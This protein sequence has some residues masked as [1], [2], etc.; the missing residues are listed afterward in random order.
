MSEKIRIIIADDSAIIRGILEKVF[1]ADGN[2]EIVDLVSNGRKAVD[3]A[4]EKE[5]DLVIS[6]IDMPEL[7]GVEA[8][9]LI[10]GQL[11]IPVAIFSENEARR[12]DASRAGALLFEKKPA[13]SSLK[14]ETLKPFA[15]H[16]R[17]SFMTVKGH[18][19]QPHK[20]DP[21]FNTFKIVVL[22]ASTG[23]PSAV[24][25]VL[26][27]LGK[28]PLPILYAQHIDVGADGKMAEWFNE[29]CPEINFQL[30][31]DGQEALP[32]NVYMAP[33][34]KHLVIDYI[35][36]MGNAV[37]KLSDDPPERFLRPAVNK[38]FRS[39]ASHYKNA[40][41]AVLMTGMGQ[42]GAEGCKAVIENSGH[43]IVEDK[44]TCTV[45]GM[46]AAAIKLGAANEIIPR[47]KI[48]ARLLEL[49]K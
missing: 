16:V 31:K 6:D 47:D 43:T 17:K 40:C 36:P 7:D 24:Q 18:K 19:P 9:K 27:G 21:T 1:K 34:E 26:N 32:G 3:A 11:E 13:L 38:L 14:M 15:E 25:T 39:A 41:L 10:R 30:A 42:D 46:P 23:G 5:P 33:A 28:F 20:A 8:T 35:N 44:S 4:R 48:A 2:F 45:F 22:G 37:M 12:D 29:S 49:V